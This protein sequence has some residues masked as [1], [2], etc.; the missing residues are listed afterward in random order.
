MMCCGAER[1]LAIQR[2]FSN[3]LLCQRHLP[4]PLRKE[5]QVHIG[6]GCLVGLFRHTL[7]NHNGV[8]DMG[9]GPGS[10]TGSAAESSASTTA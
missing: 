5:G 8:V 4:D 6:D 3:D 10:G 2:E 1:H 9:R 7:D